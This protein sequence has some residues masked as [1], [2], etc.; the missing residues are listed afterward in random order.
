MA[1]GLPLVCIVGPTASGK[2]SL[3]VDLA[4]KFGGEIICADSRTIY[5]GMDIGTA[6]PTIAEQALVPH[7]GLDLVEPGER[8]TAADF[9]SYTTE[10]INQIRSRGKIP[11]LVGGTGL[12][13]N[14]VLYD[15]QFSNEYDETLRSKLELLTIE[16]LKLYCV[17]H[18]I[19]LPENSK[20]K[21]YIIRAIEKN[22]VVREDTVLMPNA[23]VVGLTTP[24]KNKQTQN[25]RK[26]AEHM[27]EY[28]VVEEATML[29]N[30]YG[31]ESEAMKGNIYRL[32]HH[33]IDGELTKEELKD[34]FVVSDRKLA[35]RQMTWFRR[36]A[37]IQWF[38]ET[39]ANRYLSD[40]LL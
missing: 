21:R 36:D 3:A 38:T 25:I 30:K 39:E 26:R 19:K 35:K 13:V 12:Y 28:G 15:F 6:K 34:R 9:K 7:W 29:G 14:A 17:K 16:Q 24:D 1:A 22:G 33:Y 18:N 10:K 31:W 5:A 40:I 23:V 37:N 27:F 20:N 2:T 4:T 11:F 8:F 32:I